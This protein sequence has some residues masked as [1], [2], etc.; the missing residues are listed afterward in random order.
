M[1]VFLSHFHISLWNHFFNFHRLW[2]RCLFL[3]RRKVYLFLKLILNWVKINFQRFLIQ[4][5]L[6]RFEIS[7]LLIKLLVFKVD[8]L[9]VMPIII[10]PVFILRFNILQFRLIFTD[11]RSVNINKFLFLLELL[12][13]IIALLLLRFSQLVRL[14]DVEIL[15]L[16]LL[17]NHLRMLCV[18]FFGAPV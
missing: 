16:F 6:L 3:R 13:Q 15:L 5:L 18:Q 2:L 17:L 10:L 11:I 7:E 1:R 4:N 9:L 12:I 14:L 8:L